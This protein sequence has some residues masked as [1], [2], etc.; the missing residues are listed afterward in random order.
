MCG[1]L[2]T[3]KYKKHHSDWLNCIDH[4]FFYSFF[5]LFCIFVS[6]ISFVLSPS[7]LCVPPLIVLSSKRCVG[8]RRWRVWGRSWTGSC[9][10]SWAEGWPTPSP[11]PVCT[12]WA[13]TQPG[14][15]QAWHW[16]YWFAT[17]D[18]TNVTEHMSIAGGDVISHWVRCWISTLEHIEHTGK[19]FIQLYNHCNT[20]VTE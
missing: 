14:P 20:H 19:C 5:L 12:L 3:T 9:P 1:F 17:E 11:G 6:P 10:G 15:A 16:C 13:L 18:K 7:F 8:R 2:R 4:F